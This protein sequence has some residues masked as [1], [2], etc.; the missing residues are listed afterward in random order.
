[1]NEAHHKP[2]HVICQVAK[3]KHASTIT[4]GQNGTGSISRKLLGSTSDY[5]L[6][7]SDVPVMIIPT[8]PH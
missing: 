7:H 8:M 6:H 5:V 4:L 2:G 3:E 1:M